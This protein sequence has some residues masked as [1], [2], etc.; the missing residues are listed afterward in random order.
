MVPR[1]MVLVVV[2][3][4][5]VL[6]VVVVMVV[7]ERYSMKP[8]QEASTSLLLSRHCLLC[9]CIEAKYLCR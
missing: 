3:V 1:V 4:V 6:V 7:H 5:V 2:V 8:F 9:L